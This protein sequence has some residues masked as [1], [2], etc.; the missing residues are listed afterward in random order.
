MAGT[1][2]V[3]AKKG[4]YHRAIYDH[5][6]EVSL[7][8]ISIFGGFGPELVELMSRLTEER[9]NKLNKMEYE[10]TTWA[11]RTWRAFSVQRSRSPCSARRRSRSPTRSASPRR[12]TSVMASPEGLSVRGEGVD[13]GRVA[14]RV[15]GVLGGRG[16]RGGALS[17][18][19][20]GSVCPGG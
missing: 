8:L 18:R 9:K 1:G 10:Q 3:A 11:A 14:G 4:D 15:E 20:C 12:V 17:V 19:V 7:L 16:G 2:Y 6:V 13:C 5:G